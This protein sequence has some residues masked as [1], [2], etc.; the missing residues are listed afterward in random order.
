MVTVADAGM[1]DLSC[2]MRLK[3]EG[4]EVGVTWEGCECDG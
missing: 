2:G 3:E 1:G 4:D